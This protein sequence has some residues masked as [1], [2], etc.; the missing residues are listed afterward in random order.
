MHHNTMPTKRKFQDVDV[1]DSEFE[2]SEAQIICSEFLDT[3]QDLDFETIFDL[4]SRRVVDSTS[5]TTKHI[6]KESPLARFFNHEDEALQTVLHETLNPER[7][8]QLET[9]DVA[10]HMIKHCNILILKLFNKMAPEQ[11]PHYRPQV[12]GQGLQTTW[13][14]P[15]TDI[16]GAFSEQPDIL[17]LTGSPPCHHG[18]PPGAVIFYPNYLRSVQAPLPLAPPP[19]R[20]WCSPGMG[21]PIDYTARSLPI[22]ASLFCLTQTVRARTDILL[23]VARS[24]TTIT[25]CCSTA[26]TDSQRRLQRHHTTSSN[27]ASCHI[28]SG[29][30]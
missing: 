27:P 13:Y 4:C 18:L 16:P 20:Y 14:I 19:E 15:R 17:P 30:S 24:S 28:L 29:V 11:K 1:S 23:L 2:P 26:F 7:A 9:I 22:A 25:A 8:L 21:F 10:N 5:H 6:E 3:I 12:N